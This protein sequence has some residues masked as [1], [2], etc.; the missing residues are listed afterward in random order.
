[1]QLIWYVCT[2]YAP[3]YSVILIRFHCFSIDDFE[4]VIYPK[5]DREAVSISSRDLEL[6][7]PEIFVNDTIVDFYIK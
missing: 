3:N 7:L 1:M 2:V 4:D 5:G 6:L